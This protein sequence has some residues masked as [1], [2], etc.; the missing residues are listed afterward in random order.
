MVWSI[1]KV[2]HDR[3]C[4]AAAAAA[5]FPLFVVVPPSWQRVSTETHATA[6]LHDAPQL[7]SCSS[8]ADPARRRDFR[9]LLAAK[10]AC[11]T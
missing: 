5:H 7:A 4:L 1:P 10:S 9:S 3:R 2:C 11:L 6:P 8:A